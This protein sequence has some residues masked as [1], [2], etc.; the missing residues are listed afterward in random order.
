M[1]DFD[2]SHLKFE[3][4]CGAEATPTIE[5]K[6]VQFRASGIRVKLPTYSPALNLVGTQVPIF[7]WVEI[8][9][10]NGEKGRYMTLK[11]A[12]RI[13]GMERLKFNDPSFALPLT[14]GYEALGNAVNLEVVKR[15]AQKLLL[16][17][18]K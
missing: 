9:A 12:A 1:K 18:E 17:H 2:N 7:P 4:N 3:W 5:D 13:Q 15:I 16:N 10:G 14:R 11:E 8:P 6:I